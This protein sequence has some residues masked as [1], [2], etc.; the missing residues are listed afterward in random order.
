MT[1]CVGILLND[2]LVFLSNSRTYAGVDQINIFRKMAVFE[3]PCERV[4]VL[5]TSGNLAATKSLVSML[6]EAS[7]AYFQMI[8]NGW[9]EALRHAFDELPNPKL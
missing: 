7:D 8:R 2:G 1:Y 9:S 5:I 3:K 4:M 6:Q